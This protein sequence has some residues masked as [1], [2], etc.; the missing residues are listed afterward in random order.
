MTH[1]YTEK[2]ADA[3]FLEEG[4]FGINRPVW[5]I[6]VGLFMALVGLSA[7]AFPIL[8]T[9]AVE[10]FVG[11]AFFVGG[12]AAIVH[13]FMEKGWKGFFWEMAIGLL[14]V[15]AGIVLLLDPLGGVLA[16]TAVLGAT[17]V[18]EGILRIVMAIQSRDDGP[19][20][21][22]VASGAL[23]ILLGGIVLAGIVNGASFLL[24]GVLVGFNFI[25]AGTALA[26][27]G[28][29]LQNETEVEPAAQA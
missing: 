1:S 4:P 7:I 25:F 21:L 12:I 28:F 3:P 8:S 23:S 17:F 13:A 11:A 15:V 19:W 26:S 18:A 10:T 22:L 29:S 5:L 6:V 27:I 2:L 16:L 24:L 9:L 20:G 14:H